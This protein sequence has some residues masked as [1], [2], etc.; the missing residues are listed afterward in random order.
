[1]LTSA[2]FLL[3]T[4]FSPAA[5]ADGAC[6]NIDYASCFNAPEDVCLGGGGTYYGDGT[7]CVAD[8]IDCD[9]TE[10]DPDLGACCV[11]GTCID[12]ITEDECSHTFGTWYSLSSCIDV[13]SECE[14]GD[15]DPDLGACCVDGTCIDA[16]TEDE[17]KHLSGTWYGLSSCVD[18]GSECEIVDP[19]PD[20]GACCME[21]ECIETTAEEC[22][23]E[24]G[25]FYGP[26]SSCEDEYVECC[27]DPGTTGPVDPTP[28]LTCSST[29]QSRGGLRLLIPLALIGLVSGFRR[30]S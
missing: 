18:I 23:E 25:S 26:G 6:C 10:P 7:D 30:R 27:T 15:P 13:G 8:A 29:G 20:L 17:C 9:T 24:L 4:L 5:H 12:A 19:D 22:W 14:T 16:I 2:L 28:T 1:M 11:D 3:V 21:D